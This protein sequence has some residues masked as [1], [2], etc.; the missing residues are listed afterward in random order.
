M[1]TISYFFLCCLTSIPPLVNLRSING[2]VNGLGELI[3]VLLSDSSERVKGGY[4]TPLPCLAGS[5]YVGFTG[6]VHYSDEIL[7]VALSDSA[8]SVDE[9][10]VLDLVVR[11]IQYLP[12]I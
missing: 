2:V 11:D 8:P 3:V 12:V 6:G 4:F 5:E 1:T 10:L 9:E 7:Q